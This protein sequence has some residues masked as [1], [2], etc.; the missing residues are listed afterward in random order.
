MSLP[1][2]PSGFYQLLLVLI[3]F[4]IYSTDADRTKRIDNAEIDFHKS[5]N[6]FL[7]NKY[8]MTDSVNLENEYLD[9]EKTRKKINLEINSTNNDSIKL[10]K[11]REYDSVWRLGRDNLLKT[12]DVNS[13]LDALREGLNDTKED[14]DILTDLN[15]YWIIVIPCSI[16]FIV[17]LIPI[18]QEYKRNKRLISIELYNK[19]VFKN[20]QSCARIFSPVLLHGKE[21]G[22]TI[23]SGFCNDCYDE[24]EFKNPKLTAEEVIAN[25]KEL[26]PKEKYIS[27]RVMKMVRWNQNPYVDNFKF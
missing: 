16:A 6:N 1:S 12:A 19:H 9:L 21:K 10:S 8:L 22:G 20:C 11:T 4:I 23:N 2:L 24:G 5:V 7:S 25:I 18:F 13:K 26:N 15:D 3:I 27:K 17:L 14:L